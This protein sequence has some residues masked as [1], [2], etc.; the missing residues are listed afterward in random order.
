MARILIVIL[1]ASMCFAEV[2]ERE[3]EALI[4][5]KKWQPAADAYQELA[6]RNPERGSYWFRLGMALQALNKHEA[7]ISA[8]AKAR[9]L[10]FKPVGLYIRG[11]IVLDGLHRQ[12]EAITWLRELL[13]T[14][15]IA[16]ALDRIAPL[17][18]LRKSE[19]YKQL[20][21][22][23]DSPC[24]QPAY[25]ALDFWI[26]DFEVRT[27]QGQV[28]GRNRIEKILDG[29]ALQENWTSSG[30]GQGRSF[31]WFDPD[32]KRWRQ[33]YLGVNGHSHEYAGEV[34]DDGIHFL[35]D[36]RQTDGSR[37]MFRMV[38]TPQSGGRVRQLI[39][40]SWDGGLSWAIWFD[41][42]YVPAA[43]KD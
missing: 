23:Y 11:A 1:A 39:E 4:E 27:P 20:I 2:T 9:E 42:I 29:C 19:A 5:A 25:R 12:E 3:A 7:A 43:R 34:K 6:A 31:T 36:K 28:V 17:A 37:Q 24:S 15:F 14:G 22:R 40:E 13:E 41:G 38:F 26:G 32:T 10:K 16:A 8:Y 33:L 18:D 30:G 35:H 21:S